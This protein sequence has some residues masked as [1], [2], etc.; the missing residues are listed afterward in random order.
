MAGIMK[1]FR[2][3]GDGSVNSSKKSERPA[4]T[5][6]P[7]CQLGNTDALKR[8]AYQPTDDADSDVVLVCEDVA[9][10]SK[11]KR[12]DNG[13][14]KALFQSCDQRMEPNHSSEAIPSAQQ[15]QQHEHMATDQGD[16]VAQTYGAVETSDGRVAAEPLSGPTTNPKPGISAVIASEAANEAASGSLAAA[17]QAFS[18]DSA[19]QPTAKRQRVPGG[20]D[21]SAL[22][23]Q[24]Q[25]HQPQQHAQPLSQ[26]QEQQDLPNPGLQ[27]T[28]VPAPAPQSNQPSPNRDARPSASQLSFGA[29]A[30][31]GGGGA[32]DAGGSPGTAR[33][34]SPGG[35]TGA[36]SGAGAA[37]LP[38]D[39]DV[40]ARLGELRREAGEL[41]AALEEELLLDSGLAATAAA[42]EGGRLPH[43]P[44]PAELCTWLEGRTLPLSQLV[45]QLAPLLPAG[46]DPTA[47]RTWL[48]DLAQRRSYAAKEVSLDGAAASEDTTPGRLWVWEVRDPR[49][50]LADK[51]TR[52]LVDLQRKRRK[53][54]RER[55]VAVCAAVEA[56]AAL[57][58]LQAPPAPGTKGPSAAARRSAE[59]RAARSLQRLGKLAELGAV[60][61]GFRT[62]VGELAAA[63]GAAAGRREKERERKEKEEAKARQREEE[64]RAK[65]AKRAQEEEAKRKAKEA[66]AASK[67]GFHSREGLRKSQNLMESFFKRSA[68]AKSGAAAAGQ[69][70]G[71]A[72]A[73]AGGGGAG[74]EAPAAG[75]G[76]EAGEGPG[77]Q[78]PGHPHP[79]QQQHSLPP[80][81]GG[82]SQAAVAT[83]ARER[84]GPSL[85]NASKLACRQ[86]DPALVAAL[87]AA[88]SQLPLPPE[89]VAELFRE[90]HRR[91]REQ[92]RARKRMIG[93]PPTW[94]RR[95]N[96]PTD[97]RVL[98]AAYYGDVGSL[99]LR[100]GGSWAG[101]RTWRRKLIAFPKKESARPPFYGSFSKTS[102]AAGPRRPFGRDPALDYEVAS[103][104]EWEEEPEGESLSDS[105][106]EGDSHVGA[107]EGAE[108]EDDGFIVGDDHLSEDEGA[109]LS[110]DPDDP[111]EV[112]GA[113]RVPRVAAAGGPTRHLDPR[114]QQLESA[115]ERVR[116]T[117]RPVLL[118]RPPPPPPAPATAPAAAPAA[119][120]L[121][122]E[123]AAS[124]APA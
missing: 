53:E 52:K 68:A 75:G 112:D 72:A 43:T 74:L 106:D 61:A 12:E 45:G 32:G 80:A 87:D 102:T 18:P 105:G 48:V 85:F 107:G 33:A 111:M 49:K 16:E 63:G 64:A 28:P 38:A 99:E 90:D 93:V 56:L 57:Q 47:L 115:I 10:G 123:A 62:A 67:A 71:G 108:E 117:N 92:R 40:G 30:G 39:L 98:A 29:A 86:P 25:Q 34:P 120:G 59:S 84:E 15:Q 103:D 116:T 27:S 65:E 91:W 14:S 2:P 5:R 55:L 89:R 101:L 41:E 20:V 51:G 26:Q 6:E 44:S 95:P 4:T 13:V 21:A 124:A 94:S 78:A 77:S 54:L 76:A 11:R 122:E 1:F 104:E 60:E 83:P 19:R 3:T 79:Q 22:N 46:S 73:G 69:S 37:V 100:E 36:R 119:S 23:Q 82:S 17:Q 31:G 96:A 58:A 7:L 81:A 121:G 9:A 8:A 113:A 118:V 110:G 70:G 35:G 66:A 114:L 88:A 97:I 42:A 50:H 24:A 109:Q